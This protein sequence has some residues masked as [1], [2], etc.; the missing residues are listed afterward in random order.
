MREQ[1]ELL[2]HHA[3]IIA[4]HG[5]GGRAVIDR[6]TINGD[7]PFIMPLK[8]VDAADQRRFS[9]SG[10]T[11]Y[12]DFLAFVDIK[13]NVIQCRKSPNSLPTPRMLMK[14]ACFAPPLIS[15]V[16]VM[17]LR[18]S[19][20]AWIYLMLPPH[21]TRRRARRQRCRRPNLAISRLFAGLHGPSGAMTGHKGSLRLTPPKAEFNIW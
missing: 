12:D 6:N 20:H 14:P 21:L 8:P 13:I 18:N 10:R 9:R 7:L 17:W 5:T 16:S 3:D 1:I 15:V 4:Q 2:K 11:T 19:D